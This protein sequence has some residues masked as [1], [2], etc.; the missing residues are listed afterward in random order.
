[1]G[2]MDSRYVGFERYFSTRSYLLDPSYAAILGPYSAGW[3]DYVRSHLNFE[4]DLRYEVLSSVPWNF[5]EAQNRYLDMGEKLLSA[6]AAN[7][8]LRLFVASGYYDL[9]TPY[10][11]MD[12]TLSRLPLDERSVTKKTVRYYEAGHMMYVHEPSLKKLKA[13]L[14]KFLAGEYYNRS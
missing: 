7:P 12:H 9:A 10:F 14:E 11:A 3:N 2:R 1:M 5:G 4:D 6:V 8:R 13:D